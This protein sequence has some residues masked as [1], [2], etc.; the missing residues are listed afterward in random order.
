MS[1]LNIP[2]VPKCCI[3]SVCLSVCLYICMY[4]CSSVINID[5][6]HN[7][8]LDI[9]VHT[10]LI[11]PVHYLEKEHNQLWVSYNLFTVI[12][13]LSRFGCNISDLD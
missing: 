2:H 7:H 6:D 4:V 5:A 1:G 12:L 3:L 11:C 9:L 8:Y 13:T 10:L